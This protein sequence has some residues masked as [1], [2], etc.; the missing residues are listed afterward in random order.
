MSR[1]LRPW[2]LS[3]VAQFHAGLVESEAHLAPFMPWAHASAALSLEERTPFIQKWIDD[4][5]NGADFHYGYFEGD[6]FLAVIG[7]HPRIGAGGLEIGYWCRASEA[8]KG[9]TTAAVI[10]A[11]KIAFSMPDVMHVEIKHDLANIPSGRIPARLG[12]TKIAEE[13]RE[14]QAA[15]ETGRGNVWRL[16]KEQYLE[17]F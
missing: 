6:H 11:M 3:D 10:E 12:F 15:S 13:D 1:T 5:A 7:L 8:R 14:I 17:K 2:R 16:T 9:Y 4:C